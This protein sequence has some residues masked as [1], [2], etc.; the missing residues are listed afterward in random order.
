MH[1]HFACLLTPDQVIVILANQY[2]DPG[3]DGMLVDE[4]VCSDNNP[5][6]N[7]PDDIDDDDGVVAGPT[8]LAYINLAKTVRKYSISRFSLYCHG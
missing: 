3:P 4:A 5:E 6:D 1:L 7:H 2:P 8:V